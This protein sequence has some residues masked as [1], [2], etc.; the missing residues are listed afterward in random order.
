MRKIA[1]LFL[2]V[3]A[4]ALVSVGCAEVESAAKWDGTVRDSAG[5]LIVQNFGEP[6]W[7]DETHWSL[8]EVLRI[9]TVSGDPDYM[10]GNISSFV[11]LSDGTVVVA[12][13]L[14]QH[15]KFF[16]SNGAYIRTVG[17]AGSGPKEF[18]R[19][20]GVMKA[21]G[22]TLVVID[23][24]NMQAHWLASDGTWLGSWRTAPEGG[25]VL[26]GWDDAQTG[27]IVTRMSPLRT[28][29]SPVVD[30]LDVVLIRDVRGAVLDTLARVPTRQ[31]FR[32]SGDAPEWHFWAPYPD[33]DLTWR[34]GL[35]TGHSD[36]Y[37]LKWFDENGDLERIVSLPRERQP[38]TDR[39]RSLFMEKIDKMLREWDL[40]PAEIAQ[41]KS[42]VHFEDYYPAWRRF[43]CGVDGTLWI[44]R[45][46]PVSALSEQELEDM[47]RNRP[48][49]TSK[50]DVF[51][52]EGRYLGVMHMP[53][54]EMAFM[55]AGD[56]I[57]GVWEDEMD[58]Q[59]IVAWRIDGLPP[60]EEG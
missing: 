51:D 45:P 58:V 9:G 2:L 7:T 33:V 47:G 46:R 39:D 11:V 6:L 37:R 15:L 48:P 4:A 38:I 56:R 21:L 35:V 54:G 44:Q 50:W 53:T 27:R 26:R 8:T 34:G 16:T 42:A 12:D 55:F 59:Y 22:D 41:Y 31:T 14:G 10:F 32:F 60:P 3:F 52:R 57:Y 13:R 36:S 25:W 29:D 18:G 49:A 43:I 40:P 5:V 28:P 23:G 24:R 20:I 1:F 30:S 17:R 19:G